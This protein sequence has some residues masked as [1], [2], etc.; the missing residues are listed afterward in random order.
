M[1]MSHS[2]EYLSL[3]QA[4]KEG[5]YMYVDRSL[6]ETV[7]F[8]KEPTVPVSVAD[9]MAL[10]EQPSH[11][12][13]VEDGLFSTATPFESQS[14]E[15]QEMD[16]TPAQ[17]Q[18]ETGAPK[19]GKAQRGAGLI[20]MAAV[21]RAYW[22]SLF[23]LEAIKTRNSATA[24]PAPATKAPF[25]LPTVVRGGSTPSF[26]TPAEFEQIMKKSV[27]AANTKATG[28]SS[29]LKRK[30]EGDKEASDPKKPKDEK[31]LENEDEASVLAQ[32]ASMGSAWGDG[33][34]EGDS[35][36]AGPAA[37]DEVE[38]SESTSSARSNAGIVTAEVDRQSTSKI[39][40]RK[41][42]LPRCKLVA[43]ILAEYPTGAPS[44][45]V[46]ENTTDIDIIE[47]TDE[48][49]PEGPILMYLKSL[50]PPAVDLEFRALCTHENDEEGAKYNLV[51]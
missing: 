9:S 31:G 23:N 28:L 21:A 24:A 36:G 2:G 19:E 41:T 4:G 44:L 39:I 40:N 33:E 20:T 22:T 8:W 51:P 27:T 5:I 17:P 32:L 3:T 13:N 6:F 10:I 29:H 42:A 30:G 50:P 38:S 45:L 47:Q 34:E 11:D 7:H 15:S 35:W 1:A 18:V 43:F 25:F 37:V 14:E 16:V 49:P 46:L 48:E 26:P 12:A